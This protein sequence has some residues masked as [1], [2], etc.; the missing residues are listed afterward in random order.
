MDRGKRSI[1]SRS[2]GKLKRGVRTQKS[3][4]SSAGTKRSSLPPIPRKSGKQKAKLNIRQAIDEALDDYSAE[5]IREYDLY[6]SELSPTSPVKDVL[7]QEEEPDLAADDT[8]R[9]HSFD[10]QVTKS[11]ILH[12][13]RGE[14]AVEPLELAE[15]SDFER[16]ASQSP[17][18][19]RRDSAGW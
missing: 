10:L 8:K 16:R 13:K 19:T 2:E 17:G 1:Y 3:A 11:P 4:S 14:Q 6:E 7:F 15:S 5:H 12:A 9:R 18:P